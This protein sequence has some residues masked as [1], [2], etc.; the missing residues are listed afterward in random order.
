MLQPSQLVHGVMHLPPS[1]QAG[2][3]HLDRSQARGGLGGHE[4]SEPLPL[5]CRVAVI[6]HS[7]S[8]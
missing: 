7:W 2:R 5:S 1:G 3:R 4:Q 6:R 8:A